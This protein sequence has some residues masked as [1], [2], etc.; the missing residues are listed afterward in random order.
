MRSIR[1]LSLAV[2][3][4]A[5]VMAVPA[6]AQAQACGRASGH[7]PGSS[8]TTFANSI[9][10]RGVSC[11]TARRVARTWL[12]HTTTQGKVSRFNGWKYVQPAQLVR[13]TKGSAV[14]TF[15]PVDAGE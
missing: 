2:T 13:A 1:I 15:F 14:V 12:H 10:A 3:A 4:V 9:T 11:T 6:G 8:V 5:F 7:P